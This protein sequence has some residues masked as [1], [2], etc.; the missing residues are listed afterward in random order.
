MRDVVIHLI[1]SIQAYTYLD[2]AIMA[3][4]ERF[5][6]YF[7]TTFRVARGRDPSDIEIKIALIVVA[8]PYFLNDIIFFMTI[9]KTWFD[10]K[11]QVWWSQ[12]TLVCTVGY[13]PNL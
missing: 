9:G 6:R 5:T 11:V 8:I 1:S 2:D 3:Q 12:W 4:N 7:V 10:I 13:I